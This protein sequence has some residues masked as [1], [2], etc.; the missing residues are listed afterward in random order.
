MLPLLAGFLGGAMGIGT[1]GAMGIGALA[2]ALT[3]KD[4]PLLGAIGGG[5]GGFGGG[6]LG[7]A[8]GSMGSAAAPAASALSSGGAGSAMLPTLEPIG[9]ANTFNFATNATLAESPAAILGS[10]GE[11]GA[12]MGMINPIDAVST[13]PLMTTPGQG[14]S[15]GA[16]ALREAGGTVAPGLV[17][18]SQGLSNVAGGV[19]DLFSEGGWDR[20]RG[21]LGGAEGP[22][23][24]GKAAMALGMPAI[25]VAGSMGLFDPPEM[26]TVTPEEEEEYKGLWLYGD[27]S[28]KPL[29]LGKNYADGGMVQ[30]GGLMDLYSS[31]DSQ[32]TAPGQQ[33]GLSRLSN[34][35]AEQAMNNAQMGRFAEGGFLQGPGDGV[36]DNIPATIEGQ[37]PARL[38]DGEFV[39]PAR[40]VAEIGN[41]SSKAGAQRLYA[42]MDRI[43][44]ASRNRNNVA[45]DTKAYKHLPA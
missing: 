28:F 24:T 8:L 21:A 38:A 6:N 30:Q 43:E 17:G 41:G 7:T 29:N 15:G 36:S 12:N 11:I 32:P 14:L 35:T 5:L 3:N 45:S 1:L 25:S 19:K 40:I 33:Y 31:P 23:S 44:K 10:T 34:L 27:K 4:D 13:A 9:A 37:E 39:L 42:M 18:P 2:G 26:E 16:L 20:F 22:V